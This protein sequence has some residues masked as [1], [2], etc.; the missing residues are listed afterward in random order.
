MIE[1]VLI[2]KKI[3]TEYLSM[4]AV[5]LALKNVIFLTILITVFIIL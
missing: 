1:A 5:I 3:P 4:I 2:T